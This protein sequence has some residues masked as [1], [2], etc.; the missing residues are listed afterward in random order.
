MFESGITAK[1]FIENLKIE[2]DVALPISDETYL[3][4]LNATEQ[5]L[6]G[7]V[8][9]EEGLHRFSGTEIELP[10]KR[11]NE[12]G[13]CSHDIVTVYAVL[14]PVRRVQLLHVTPANAETFKDVYYVLDEN[15][16]TSLSFPCEDIDL[17]YTKRPTIKTEENYTSGTV[18]IPVEFIEL[19]ASKLRGEAYKLA[20]EDSIAGKWLNDY[21]AHLQDFS[22]WCVSKRADIG[23]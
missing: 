9:K 22:A 15:L 20:N 1:A 5:F 3:A 17:V 14:T 12:A 16:C 11:T 21:N 23:M 10:I 6:Y 8:I 4:W 7:S 18:K 2:I 13:I 19:I